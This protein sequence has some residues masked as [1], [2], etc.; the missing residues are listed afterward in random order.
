MLRRAFEIFQ[1]KELGKALQD[2]SLPVNRYLREILTNRFE[3]FF[4]GILFYFIF[5]S[6]K[7]K[8]FIINWGNGV[9]RVVHR[10]HKHASHI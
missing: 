8:I 10:K 7:Y 4:L 9:V 1:S 2:S 5:L 3:L 6:S